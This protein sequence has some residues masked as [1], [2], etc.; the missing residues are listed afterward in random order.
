MCRTICIYIYIV[1]HIWGLHFQQTF[2]VVTYR[3]LG[4]LINVLFISR[5][6]RMF[7]SFGCG[8]WSGGCGWCSLGCVWCSLGGWCSMSLSWTCLLLPGMWLV[9]WWIAQRIIFCQ[10][11]CPISQTSGFVRVES[12]LVYFTRFVFGFVVAG[13]CF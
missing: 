8:W 1:L 6:I 3:K 4:V 7:G 13:H 11:F 9:V 12:K 2:S 5:E 10:L